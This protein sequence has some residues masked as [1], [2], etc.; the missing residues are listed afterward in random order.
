MHREIPEK[1]KWIRSIHNNLFFGN[2]LV[3]N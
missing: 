3:R 2:F 1:A